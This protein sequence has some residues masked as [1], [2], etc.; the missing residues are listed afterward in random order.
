MKLAVMQPYLFPYIGYF[1]L[2][3]VSDLFLIYDD[4]TFIKKGYIN[5]NNVLTGSGVTRFTVSV[6][7]ASQNKLITE[8]SFSTDVNKIL[9]IVEHGYSMA[10]YFEAFFPLFKQIV[11]NK[12]RSISSVCLNSYQA[13]FSY[14]DIEKK[15]KR[16][17][18]LEYDR[19]AS[20]RDRLINLSHKFGAD[21]YINSPSGRKLYN[22]ADFE[23]Q[24][25]DLK[26][27]DSLPVEYKQNSKEFVP[28]LS[29]IDVLMNCSPEEVR[30]LLVRY[31][32]G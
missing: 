31:K 15:F 11:E 5:R 6:P 14:L 24:G 29:I 17:S 13:I 30:N 8:L 3:Y 4:V 21:C 23:N 32:L 20:A 10:P 26:F 9:K 1:H 27:V 2:I 22:K 18:E 16:T 12:E 28:N 19:S 25:I 7:G